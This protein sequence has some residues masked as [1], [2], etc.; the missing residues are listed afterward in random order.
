MTEGQGNRSTL[1]W[2]AQ[3]DTRIKLLI[4]RTRGR[5]EILLHLYKYPSP[6][7]DNCSLSSEKVVVLW[8]KIAS[9]DRRNDLH[10]ER[11]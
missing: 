10:L 8:R 1:F 2:L 9:G 4:R 7:K 3:Q 5:T 6:V 11:R